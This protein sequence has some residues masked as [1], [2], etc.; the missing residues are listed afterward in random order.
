M[1]DNP[2]S[3][4]DSVGA[5]VVECFALLEEIEQA[6]EDHFS[7]PCESCTWGHAADAARYAEALRQVADL[8]LGRGEYARTESAS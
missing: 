7:I 5:S 3:A 1:S 4:V 6:V 2:E 8:I